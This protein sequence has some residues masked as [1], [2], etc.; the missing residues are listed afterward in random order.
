MT[1][2]QREPPHS[3]EAE[4][5]LLGIVLVDA[6]GSL[7]KLAE[8]DELDFFVPESRAIWNAIERVSEKEGA[9]G[10]NPISV[11]ENLK[12]EN[13]SP[14]VENGF[15]G[16][17]AYA[18]S[19]P[20][21]Q[22]LEY[23]AK[24]LRDKRILREVIAF[25]RESA[26]RA[27]GGVNAS[28][29]VADIWNG[30]GRLQCMGTMDTGP[31]RVGDALGELA[32]VIEHRQSTG[33]LGDVMTKIEGIDARLGGLRRQQFTVIAAGP[34]VGK[35]ALGT[36]ICVNV[37]IQ[38]VPTLIFSAEMARGELLERMIAGQSR[39]PIDRI[40]MGRAWPEF[41][42]G[43]GVLEP[44]PLWIDDSK[45]SLDEV[46]GTA[47]RWHAQHVMGG[48][49]RK[50]GE[51]FPL[52]LMM[53]DY[54]QIFEVK[55]QVERRD[56]EVAMVSHALKA[57]AKS[58]HIPV[59]GIS[60]VNRKGQEAGQVVGLSSMRESGAIE[61]D[62]DMVLIIH[63]EIKEGDPESRNR[64]G[65]VDLLCVKNRGGR[66]GRIPLWWDQDWTTFRDPDREDEEPRQE[67][68]PL[69][70]AA[71]W[72]DSSDPKHRGP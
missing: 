67:S 61:Y 14:R 71:V 54:L 41:H 5:A 17:M 57:M 36:N 23:H 15:N 6:A 29:L 47:Y 3:L 64:S 68:L 62:A 20:I 50:G 40:A 31:V 21:P 55:D 24:T 48:H 13:E 18:T 22:Q 69:A 28:E 10:I 26:S 51:E 35:S 42:Q 72:M 30:A 65:P 11:W 59:I 8:L 9:A 37:A 56:R 52:A 38:N 4:R 27:Y 25:S 33:R 1:W 53:F 49:S 70:K 66:L 43:A 39:T 60:A 46:M 12:A 58:L 44:A 45:M 2:D 7:A 63:R 34:N 32:S 19:A 16:L